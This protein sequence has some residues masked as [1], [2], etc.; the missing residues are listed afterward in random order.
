MQNFEFEHEGKK[1]WY[2]RSV[3]VSVF[4]FAHVKGFKDVYIL[5]NKRG[6][7]VSESGKWCVPGGFLDFNETTKDAA[8]R[9]VFEETGLKLKENADFVF[10]GLNDNPDDNPSQNVTIR[11][12]VNVGVLDQ[13]NL[14]C[15]T[16][17]NADKNE[18]TNVKFINIKDL[19]DYEWAFNLKELILKYA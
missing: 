4:V 8:K 14:S 19:D 7:A 9:E 10:L 1:Y 15:L 12:R 13:L 3:C 11:Y 17:K 5:A 6:T 2:S 16:N 18:V